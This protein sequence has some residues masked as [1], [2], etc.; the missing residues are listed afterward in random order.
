MENVLQ[1][2]QDINITVKVFHLEIEKHSKLSKID[3]S[4][5]LRIFE[6]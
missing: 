2:N 1:D 3:T 5:S 6:I 4:F